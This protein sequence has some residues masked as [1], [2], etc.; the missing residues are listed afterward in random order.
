MTADRQRG[1]GPSEVHWTTK[2]PSS[3][4][5]GPE[6]IM[7]RPEKIS[8]EAEAAKT[9]ADIWELFITPEM[10][11]N[12]TRWTNQKIL[13]DMDEHQYS[14]DK[15]LKCPYLKTVDEVDVFLY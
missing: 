13:E 11:T 6:D 2:T 7:S 4:K 10:V 3:R 8:A 15:L 5:R 12:I 14:R 1:K 9:T